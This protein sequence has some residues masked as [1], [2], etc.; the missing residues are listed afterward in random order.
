[1]ITIGEFRYKAVAVFGLGKAG[2]AAIRALISSGAEVFAWDDNESGRKQF[3]QLSFAKD[4]RLAPPD[5]YN[6]ERISALVLSPGVPLTHPTPHPIVGMAKKAN[7]PIICDVELLYR[8]SPEAKYIG[9]T[10]TNGKSTTTALIGHL[11]KHAGKETEVGGNIGTAASELKMLDD[12]GVYVIELSSYQLD[13]L[14]K[15]RVNV[16]ILL[17][18]TPDHLDR[19]G[20]MEGYLKA[21]LHIFE[22][23]TERDYAIIAVD[24]Q[25]TQR[26]YKSMKERGRQ[27]VIAVSNSIE[28]SEGVYVSGGVVYIRLGGK[29]KKFALGELVHLRGKHNWQNIAAAVAALYVS[30]VDVK[31]IAAGIKT[32]VGLPHRIQLVDEID[33]VQFINDSKA[34]NAEA[35]EKAITSFKKKKI[36]LIAGGKPKEGGIASL[37]P[38]FPKLKHVYLIGEAAKDFAATLDAGKVPYSHCGTLERALKVASKEAFS[39]LGEKPVILLSPACASFDQFKNYEERGELFCR[40]VKEIRKDVT[41]NQHRAG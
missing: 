33:G 27:Q 35:A 31:V 20:N 5:T 12:R 17:N 13:L 15:M 16:A 29:E 3:Q 10:G 34:T 25:Y 21:K 19:H 37:A 9:I 39:T 36:L 1:V 14:E 30:G 2:N 24:D 11:F 40:L 6:W 32:F 18:L 26:V 41:Q 28:L 23:Q 7:C 8:A 22:R 4:V 38:H